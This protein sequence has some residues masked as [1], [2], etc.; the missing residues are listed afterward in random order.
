VASVREKV[1]LQY[2]I[3]LRYKKSVAYI[4]A[5]TEDDRRHA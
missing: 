4:Q 5:M 3:Y 2:N 1:A